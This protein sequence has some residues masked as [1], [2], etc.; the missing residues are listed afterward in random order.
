MARI[1]NLVIDLKKGILFA[2]TFGI[3][4]FLIAVPSM[5]P[6]GIDF[7]MM[8]AITFLVLIIII[9]ILYATKRMN[10][11]EVAL[12]VIAY[13][14]VLL[15]VVF[16]IIPSYAVSISSGPILDDNWWQALNWM[17]N[18]TQECAVIATYWDPGHFI[19]GIAQ[20][21]VIYDG[22]SQNALL[23]LNS[24]RISELGIDISK[25]QEGINF[26]RYDKGIT[27]IIVRRGDTL[28]S[29]RMKD[30]ASAMFTDNETL[31]VELLKRYKKPNCS[32]MYFLA[33]SDLIGKSTWWTYF[34]TWDPMIDCDTSLCKGT[35]RN[36]MILSLGGKKPLFSEGVVGYEYPLSQAQSIIL[37]QKND[38]I[39]A[40]LQN[41]NQFRKI[42]RIIY[43]TQTGLYVMDNPDADVPGTVLLLDPSFGSIMYMP[44]ELENAMYTRMMFF[45][46]EGL[47][48]FKLVNSWGFE[49]KLYKIDFNETE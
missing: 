22:A 34:S 39:T 27:E 49:V 47:K 10:K 42:K 9:A 18:N 40:L 5:Y 19:T 36:Y 14:T 8:T 4:A 16:Y 32:E 20:R 35:P 3:L 24:T 25:Y 11:A 37:Y 6:I 30:V 2:I 12:S 26:E 15:S 38:T 23:E 1:R 13:F 45:N 29:S 43:P 28:I 46:G 17:K 41:G 48:H 31:A 7:S 33:T 21:P 44:A